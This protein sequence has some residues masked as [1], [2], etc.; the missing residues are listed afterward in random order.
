MHISKPFPNVLVA[1][2]FGRR[3]SIRAASD[4]D[5]SKLLNIGARPI[6]AGISNDNGEDNALLCAKPS[7]HD[8]Y[9]HH[10]QFKLKLRTYLR[11]EK[12]PSESPSPSG[13][14][15]GMAL[16]PSSLPLPLPEPD[17]GTAAV[18]GDEFQAGGYD[19]RTQKS[20]AAIIAAPKQ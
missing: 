20:M 6:R 2:V 13:R 12:A 19:E 18:L 4:F 1:E 5:Q 7:G 10:S 9:T 11:E 15:A 16:A 17:P 3:L 14:A 8:L